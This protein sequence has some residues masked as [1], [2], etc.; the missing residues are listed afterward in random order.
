MAQPDLCATTTLTT[1]IELGL[2]LKLIIYA[3]PLPTIDLSQRTSVVN[4]MNSFGFDRQ[5]VFEL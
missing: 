4:Y 2:V 5:G 1:Q 3:L